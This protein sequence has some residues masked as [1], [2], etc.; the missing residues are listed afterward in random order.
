MVKQRDDRPL[1]CLFGGALDTGNHGVS[2]LGLASIAAIGRYAPEAR[3]VLFDNGLGPRPTEIDFGSTRVSILQRGSR[4]SRRLH[5]AESVWNM[6]ASTLTRPTLNPNVAEISRADLVLDITAGDGFSD[7]YGRKTFTGST[8]TKRMV[9][10]LG[11]PLVLLPQT[12]GPFSDHDRRKLAADIV[13]K[14]HAAWARDGDSYAQLRELLGD[15]FDD[16]RHHQGVDVAFALPS[17]PVTGEIEG[18]ED[19]T[20]RERPLVG[21]NVSGLLY[22]DPET[23]RARF[24]LKCDYPEAMR[25]LVAGF[26]AEDIDVLLV[27]HVRGQY[28]RTSDDDA[29]HRLIAELPTSGRVRTL[30]PGLG[31][32]ETKWVIEQLDWFCG[33]RMHATIAALSTGTPVAGIAYSHKMRG[34]FATC[35][36][37]DEDVIDARAVTT[38]EMLERLW[39]RWEQRDAVHARLE[40]G[41]WPVRRRAEEQFAS[42]LAPITG[43]RLPPGG[44]AE[45]LVDV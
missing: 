9:L 8:A 36:L 30:P 17:E 4:V 22:N 41:R 12:Y 33:P 28:G 5:R 13:A 15:R 24:S 10:R 43:G 21:V 18:L 19:R 40:T 16:S 32:S 37:G 2:A 35:G 31:P 20:Q 11:S 7:I 39:D 38:D 25:Q 27:P 34:V 44:T 3:I 23:A 42:V 6:W 1:V 45:G 14:S 26:V 29:C